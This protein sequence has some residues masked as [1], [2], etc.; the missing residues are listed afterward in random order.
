MNG[1]LASLAQRTLSLGPRIEPWPRSTFEPAPMRYRARET[2]VEDAERTAPGDINASSEGDTKTQ[3]I[4]SR[5]S[6]AEPLGLTAAATAKPDLDQ[7]ETLLPLRPEPQMRESPGPEEPQFR[8]SKRA[9]AD[10]VSIASL[11]PAEDSRADARPERNPIGLPQDEAPETQPTPAPGELRLTPRVIRPL[12]VSPTADPAKVF[13][14]G[15]H[16]PPSGL[17]PVVRVTIG[18]VEVRA[19][20]S[21]PPSAPRQPAKSRPTLSLEDYLKARNG[22]GR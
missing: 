8:P 7:E 17:S 14:D 22:G 2:T 20:F 5:A 4:E 12:S 21:F 18:R 11:A 9:L 13:G 16:H 15:E 6:K 3:R 19:N 10:T 1:Y